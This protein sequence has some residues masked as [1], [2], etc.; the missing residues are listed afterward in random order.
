MNKAKITSPAAMSE[1]QLKEDIAMT[2]LERLTL[3][4]KIS[5]FAR[6]LRPD[7]ESIKEE[8]PSIQWLEVRKIPS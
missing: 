1:E 2:P 7:K 3:A 6:D 4:F 5:D 8:S